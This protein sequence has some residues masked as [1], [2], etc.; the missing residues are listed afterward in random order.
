[1]KSIWLNL[2]ASAIVLLVGGGRSLLLGGYAR[3]HV[4]DEMH[5]GEH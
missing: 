1:M 4:V 5:E 3:E 2:H